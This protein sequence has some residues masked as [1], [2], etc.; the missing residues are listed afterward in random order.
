M[1]G[2]RP[3]VG[4]SGWTYKPWRGVF[5]PEGLVQRRELEY[6]S[7][8]FR[9]IEINGTFY[10][11][12]K[13]DAFRRWRE[14]TPDGFVFAVKGSRYITHTRRL[15]EIEKPLANFL[16]S[17]V[18]ALEE[19]LG[20]ILWQ[21]PPSL[22]FD[23]ERLDAFL[24]LLPSDTEE[25][26]RLA[27]RHD[28]RLNGRSW[29]RPGRKR[30][31]RHALEVRHDSF[32]TKEFIDL[33]RRHKTALVFTDAVDWPY[34]EDVTADFIYLR[35]HGSEEL[36]ASGYSKKA[37]DRWADRVGKWAAGGEPAD[38]E[39]IDGKARKRESG[40]RV[41]VYFDNDAKVRAPFD[42]SGLMERLGLEPSG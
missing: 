21:L 14:E 2:P 16:A 1:G 26:A 24:S 25:A 39:R 23:A 30:T 18:L 20:P 12:Q 33:L 41:H 40:R 10:G 8:Q 22:R 27:K 37:L 15:K 34:M 6:A 38:S 9:S 32:K 4:I 36:Y 42:A 7:R 35:L 17:G 5:Y 29:M 11:L 31:L 13:P 3:L 28:D 19:K